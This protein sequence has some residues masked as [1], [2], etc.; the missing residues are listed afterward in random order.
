MPQKQFE[1]FGFDR[2]IYS[3]FK[4]GRKRW[5]EELKEHR[6]RDIDT[7]MSQY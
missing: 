6:A 4:K 5:H 7:E 2:T 1:F 3:N